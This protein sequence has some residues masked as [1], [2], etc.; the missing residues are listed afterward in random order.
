MCAHQSL[1]YSVRRSFCQAKVPLKWSRVTYLLQPCSEWLGQK[2]TR[3]NLSTCMPSHVR[4][5]RAWLK[6]RDATTRNPLSCSIHCFTVTLYYLWQTTSSRGR[7]LPN[8]IQSIV[9]VL[10]NI[11]KAHQTPCIISTSYQ[12]LLNPF[13]EA[14]KASSL[15]VCSSKSA[16]VEFYCYLS[17]WQFNFFDSKIG[18][19]WNLKTTGLHCFLSCSLYLSCY[20]LLERVGI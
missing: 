7:Y 10:V 8:K 17:H 13:T 15:F 6:Q 11:T 2:I 20:G 9:L 14:F 1:P 12:L 19:D 16:G 4:S 5:S 18:L 3:E